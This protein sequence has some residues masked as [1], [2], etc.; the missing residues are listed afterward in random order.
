MISISSSQISLFDH[1]FFHTLYCKVSNVSI[2]LY[3]RFHFTK[4]HRQTD[5]PINNGTFKSCSGP[6]KT[7]SENHQKYQNICF[8]FK[9]GKLYIYWG[10]NPTFSLFHQSSSVHPVSEAGGATLSLIQDK[11][12]N[13]QKHNIGW[14]NLSYCLAGQ[15]NKGA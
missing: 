9:N 14:N 7:K 15:L 10:G 6:L 3:E 1:N 5:R 12:M 2:L 4:V 13:R 11:R 8:V